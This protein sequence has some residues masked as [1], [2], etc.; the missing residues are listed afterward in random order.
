VEVRKMRVL[1][2]NMEVRQIEMKKSKMN[3]R[4]PST[5]PTKEIKHKKTK[6]KFSA[7]NPNSLLVYGISPI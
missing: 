3:K 4:K 7:Y 2:M 6:L 5:H 1:C